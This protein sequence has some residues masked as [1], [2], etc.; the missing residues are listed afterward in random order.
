M[1]DR[2]KILTIK[3]KRSRK[4]SREMLKIPTK[5]QSTLDGVC[6]T[7]RAGFCPENGAVL[8]LYGFRW[9]ERDRNKFDE[10]SPCSTTEPAACNPE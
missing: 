7:Y 2:D 9:T 6:G 3:R 8:M 1:R 10:N 5:R 4:T